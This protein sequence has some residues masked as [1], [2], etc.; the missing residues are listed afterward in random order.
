M[1]KVFL[2]LLNVGIA[3]GWLILAV[4]ILRF[5][6]RKA[7]KWTICLLWALVALRLVFPFSIESVFS[8]I[9]SAQTVSI[10][11][12]RMEEPVIHTGIHYV[13]DRVN[14]VIT[15]QMAPKM[16]ESVN[17]MQVVTFVASIVWIIGLALFQ[18]YTFVS[19]VE[20][21]RKVRIAV[22]MQRYA[23]EL[24]EQ[25]EWKA[26]KKVY[27]C[28]NIKSSFILG[29]VNPKV[30]L[31]AG[32]EDGAYRNILQHEQTHLKRGDQFWKPL[33]YLLMSVYWFQPLC[34][35]AYTFFCKDIELACDERATR[36]M[37]KEEK[38]SYCQTL[39]SCSTNRRILAACP[40]AFGEVGVKERVKHVFNYKKP[41]FWIILAACAAC[42]VVAV[43]FLTNPK[44]ENDAAEG[45]KV[46]GTE[47]AEEADTGTAETVSGTENEEVDITRISD[48]MYEK[49]FGEIDGNRVSVQVEQPYEEEGT[50]YD[51]HQ[52]LFWNGTMIWEYSEVNYVDPSSV[53]YLD[54]DEDGEKEIFYTFAPRVN[55]AG[56]VEYV[57]LKQQGDEWHPLQMQQEGNLAENNFT[58]SV[59]YQ[60]NY[61]VE[62]SCEG[63]DKTIYY[64]VKEH[65]E[66]MLEDEIETA[67]EQGFTDARVS[68]YQPYLDDTVA[69]AGDEYGCLAAWG[70]WD[71]RPA[72][73]DNEAKNC[74]VATYGI[75]GLEG[76]F[77]FFGYLDVYFNYD[78]RGNYQILDMQFSEYYPVE[79]GASSYEEVID[80]YRDM[81]QNRFYLDVL[82]TDEREASFGPDIG[83]EIRMLVQNVFYALYDIDGNG[84]E[85]LIIAA[86]EQGVGVE[87]PDFMP[88]NYDL[89]TYRDGKV[90]HVFSDY[91]FGYRTNFEL[92]ENGRIE[93]TS[94][95]S[96][97][98][99]TV[100][101][102]RIGADGASPVVIDNF[103]CIGEKI[104]DKT[105]VF[106]HYQNGRPITEEEYN[107]K[108]EDYAKQLKGLEWQEI[109]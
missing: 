47:T 97:A 84:T 43:C 109:Y 102:F 56:L 75:Q 66:R 21:K 76:K 61:N 104:D 36:D 101:F 51:S 12:E 103:A 65:Y 85:E 46:A 28:D 9:P 69:V 41:T 87:S 91:G 108:I 73:Y 30:Y 38:A 8:L 14:P 1:T 3:A 15:E 29:I 2:T 24:F 6:L 31:P 49:S 44:S 39:L 34:W 100:T 82:N 35:V 52:K 62:I 107:R 72:V 106:Q 90:V 88:R 17:P 54:L 33:G 4:L 40:V 53:E 74:L 58:V 81:V 13:D 11:I 22:P 99:S 89:Y 86:G 26:Y 80:E 78:R 79:S 48:S 42:I 98:E 32:M 95:S 57:V 93:V 94:N 23:P 71:I 77:D 70:M 10:E 55:S 20:L 50:D 60:E 25:A 63:T 59:I 96:A 64:N 5:L 68:M 19:Y 16:E 83:L 67:K 105:V 37:K 27:V 18:T 7:P 45:I 92:C